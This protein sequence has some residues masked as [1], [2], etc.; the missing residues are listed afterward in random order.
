MRRRDILTALPGAALVASAAAAAA[1]VPKL[2]GVNI[3]I[4]DIK[5]VRLRVLKEL[6]TLAGF[7]GPW[8]VNQVTL[9]GGSFLEV[10]TD[11][12]LI[13]IGSAIDPVQLPRLREGV[14]GRDPFDVQQIVSDLRDVTY[15]R[16]LSARPRAPGKAEDPMAMPLALAN[17]R[18]GD[19]S[20]DRAMCAIEIALWDII[21]KACNKP[22]YKLWGAVRERVTPYASQS[23]LG[24]PK[25][26]AELAAQLKADGWKAI[27][28]RAHFP[29]MKEN[30]RLVEEARK[31]VG[32][33]FDIMC[34]ANQ[35]TNTALT[36]DPPWGFQRSVDTA[37]AYHDLN[38]YWLEE[39]L[40]RYDLEGLTELNRRVD[41]PL[42]GGE[43]NRGLNEF[44][45]LAVKGCYDI[46]MPEIMLLGPILFRKIA[47]LAEAMDKRVSPHLAEGR[48]ATVCNMHLVASLPN[49]E[50][51]EIDH[52]LPLKAYSNGMSIF[53]NPPVFQKG[54]Y[55]NVPQG[56]GLGVTIN[57]DLILA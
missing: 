55:F 43:G 50:Y 5:I 13:G 15:F 46:L 11:Q 42:A 16:R 32:D 6:G 14:I 39:P 30:I 52:D 29:T 44:R 40:G 12:G 37:K 54:G 3:K 48:V 36:P 57:K 47:A 51:L 20:F 53:E 24:D 7:N 22:L 34:D 17:G 56:P 10:H 41:V 9:G 38:V 1:Q 21:G 31:L 18:G 27:K 19:T 25:S 23:R 26:R 8:D 49:A 4:T 2:T 45:D 28:Y 35:A 33:D